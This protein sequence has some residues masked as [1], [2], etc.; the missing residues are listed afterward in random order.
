MV[1]HG[2]TGLLYRFEEVE[3]LAQCIRAVLT[4]D[5]LAKRLS[6]SGIAVAEQR[7]NRQTILTQTIKTYGRV[8]S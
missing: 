5:G 4:D 6:V 2:E 8:S 3:M 7:H 1:I